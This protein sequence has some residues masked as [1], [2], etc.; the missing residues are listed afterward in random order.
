MSDFGKT[1]K[2]VKSWEKKR[3]KD[4]ISGEYL[5]KSVNLDELADEV[6]VLLESGNFSFLKVPFRQ[7]LSLLPFVINYQVTG[8]DNGV[9]S[10]AW[11]STRIISSLGIVVTGLDYKPIYDNASIWSRSKI[12]G[13]IDIAG[14]VILN[15]TPNADFII[16]YYYQLHA[17]EVIDGYTVE[18]ILRPPEITEDLLGTNVLARPDIPSNYTPIQTGSEGIDKISAHLKGIDTKL[19]ML[20]LSNYYTESEVDTLLLNKADTSHTHVPSHIIGLS[21]DSVGLGN[22]TD[23]S[24]LKRSAG[25]FISFMEKSSVVGSDILIIE[26]SSDSNN[27]KYVQV[28]NLPSSGGSIDASS[29]LGIAVDDSNIADGRVLQYTEGSPDVLE[30]VDISTTGSD[31]Q[32]VI[33][34]CDTSVAV[35]NLVYVSNYIDNYAVKAIDNKSGSPVIGIVVEKIDSTTAKIQVTNEP[36]ITY[37]GLTLGEKVFVSS[38]GVPTTSL[39][40]GGY[41]QIIGICKDVNKVF[42]NVDYRRIKQNPF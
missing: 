11:D 17:G 39:P 22:V 37:S 42:L 36:N 6:R 10:Q 19:G 20:D 33:L 4:V 24:Q 14:N 8:N 15:A 16:H 5:E 21:K 28:S 38:T 26:D 31:T 3:V 2:P 40:V 1:N 34:D 35:N 27:K 30:Y 41:I 32:Y 13:A 9:T 7:Q 25:D 18:D 29:I 12:V 23:D